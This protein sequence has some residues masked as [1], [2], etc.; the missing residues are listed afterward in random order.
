[1]TVCGQVMAEQLTP[2]QALA[3]VGAQTRSAEPQLVYTSSQ[4]LGNT[5]YAFNQQNG[6]YLI[7]SADDCMPAVLGY[8]DNGSFDYNNLPS[9]MKWFLGR[10]DAAVASR[11]TQGATRAATRTLE[12][13]AIS[14]LLGGIK[15]DQG[16]PYN[17]MSPVY[18]EQHVPTG[19]VATAMAQVMRYHKWPITGQGS[20]TYKTKIEVTTGVYSDEEYTYS[21]DFS[22]ITFDWE[23]MLESY[24][25]DEETGEG[26]Y[27][28]EQGEAVATLLYSCG[29]AANMVWGTDDAGGSAATSTDAA[30]GMVNYFNYDSEMTV[31]TKDADEEGQTGY[32]DEEWDQTIYDQLQNYGPVIFG[33]V[34]A[35]GSGGH[36]FV[37][38]GFDG[39]GKFHINWGW[40]GS[41]DGYFVLTGPGLIPDSAGAGSSQEGVGA[42]YGYQLEAIV[43]IK[44]NKESSNIETASDNAEKSAKFNLQGQ[45]VETVNSGEIFVQ[46]GAKKIQK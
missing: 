23:N 30:Q 38:D 35:E 42:S 22:T 20:N 1:M 17:D 14:P 46:G 26:N 29:V 19:C 4:K 6:G 9:N 45:K 7:L 43:N 34:G 36:E 5:Y 21:L 16:T 10:L 2:A 12:A 39:E 27:T 33:G 41:S 11:M 28:Q 18:N 44:P 25:Y 24:S 40:S 15:Y 8:S 37:C 13:E 3:R 32:T 31:I